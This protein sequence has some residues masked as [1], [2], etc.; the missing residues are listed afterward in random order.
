MAAAGAPHGTAVVA[1]LQRSG[2]GRS[3][4]VW[5]SPPGNLYV[6]TVLRPGDDPRRAPELGFVV[7]LALAEAVDEL[8]GRGT[9]LKWPNDVLRGGAKMAGILLERLEDGAVLAGLGV[10]VRHAPADMPYAVTSLVAEGGP[11]DPEILLT[12]L[13]ARLESGWQQWQADGFA[14]VLARWVVRGPEPGAA[15]QVRLPQEVVAGRFAGL[16]PNGGLQLDTPTGRRTL[17]AGDVVL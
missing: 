5:T 14:A 4:R 3:G 15:I 12:A 10:N 16:A 6:T 2:R 8:A 17:V 1:A 9:R 11:A 13:L 7:A